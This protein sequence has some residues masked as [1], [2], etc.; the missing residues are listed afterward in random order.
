[1]RYEIISGPPQRFVCSGNS[2]YGMVRVRDTADPAH[3]EYDARVDLSWDATHQ[4]RVTVNAPSGAVTENIDDTFLA[5]YQGLARV[6]G[7]GTADQQAYCRDMHADTAPT[8]TPT[9]PTPAPELTPSGREPLSMWWLTIPT[10]TRG[11]GYGVRRLSLNDL[12]V[13]SPD[14]DITGTVNGV[15]LGLDAATTISYQL[16]NP[17]QS[18]TMWYVSNGGLLLWSGVM[19]G[20]AFGAAGNNHG[21]ELHECVG[22]PMDIAA[23][24]GYRYL[25]AWGVPIEL[26]EGGLVLGLSFLLPGTQRL[27]PSLIAAPADLPPGSR[28]VA[29]NPL[30]SERFPASRIDL[31]GLG[32]THMAN[33]FLIQLPYRVITGHQ[34][35]PTAPRIS[36]TS[37]PGGAFGNVVVGF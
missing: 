36:V 29:G 30:E 22:G 34:P 32:A 25:G 5:A 26:A 35:P 13:A 31:L 9:P 28:G 23:S 20:V 11:L 24:A 12:R 2:A 1:M 18:N 8:P 37:L 3:P 7:G 17:D 10:L 4:A 15:A 19:C 14:A 6:T 27:T 33:A 16:T 21:P